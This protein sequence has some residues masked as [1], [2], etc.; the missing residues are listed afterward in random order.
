VGAHGEREPITVVWGQ[1]PQR[2][3][4]AKPKA[5]LSFRSANEAQFAHFC[6]SCKLLKYVFKRLLLRFC[7]RHQS[8]P[9]V[10]CCLL[11]NQSVGVYAAVFNRC[12]CSLCS[13]PVACSW[14]QC[15]T[16]NRTKVIHIR[17]YITHRNA[18][19]VRKTKPWS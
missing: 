7:H 6:L 14:P 19:K 8:L 18:V 17:K 13:S 15:A 5:F 2:G 3:P 10:R 16:A 9:M 1:I 4:G 12:A 11:L